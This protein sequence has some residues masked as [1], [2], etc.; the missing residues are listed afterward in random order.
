MVRRGPIKVFLR[1]LE[2]RPV[3]GDGRG[4]GGALSIAELT[5]ILKADTAPPHLAPGAVLHTDSAKS[6]KK[7]GPMFW[8]AP[9]AHTADFEAQHPF[10]Q[11]AWVHTNVCHKPKAGEGV[12]W[13][14]VA[15]IRH[16][17][18]ARRLV[19]KGT[20]KIDGFWASLR[21]AVGR[22]PFI[23]GSLSDIDRQLWLECTVLAFQWRWWNLSRERFVLL[24]NIFREQ[25]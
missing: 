1:R 17:G 22:V 9:G 7:L 14:E 10:L 24:G 25:R 18:G 20:E 12:R 5:R 6:Y 15:E 16:R 23:T 4:G 11:H 2:N 3:H 19:Q 8:P 21:R 13:V